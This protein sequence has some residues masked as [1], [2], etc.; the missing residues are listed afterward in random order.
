MTF[1]GLADYFERLVPHRAL[2]R[3]RLLTVSPQRGT[4]VDRPAVVAHVRRGDFPVPWRTSDAWYVAAIDLVRRCGHDGAIHLI[5]DAEDDELSALVQHGATVL[6]GADALDELWILARADIILA[7]GIST[8]ASWASFLGSGVTLA[9]SHLDITGL[10][11]LLPE[12]VRRVG[13]DGAPGD[14]ADLI[15]RALEGG[16]M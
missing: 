13:S 15:V 2:V 9:P 14:T 4:P 10:D 16:G 8:F 1:T 3:D 12:R 5:S 11:R 6:R 7:S